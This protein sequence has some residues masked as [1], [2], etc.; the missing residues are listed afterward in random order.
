MKLIEALNTPADQKPAHYQKEL[1]TILTRGEKV[2]KAFPLATDIFVF[3]DK[4]L[5]IAEAIT[6]GSVSAACHSIPYRS[7][8]HF[9]FTPAAA[10]AEGLQLS[11]WLHGDP[12]PFQLVLAP[13]P[14]NTEL[15]KTLAEYVLNRHS[16]WLNQQMAWKKQS[17]LRTVQAMGLTGAAVLSLLYYRKKHPKP[18]SPLTER[19]SPVALAALLRS[20]RK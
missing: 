15:Q 7:I 13:A 19:L 20:G 10:P 17:G 1:K 18:K 12:A 9:S 11:L 5:I 3:T 14:Q 2:E 4:R 6:V 16:T 8:A